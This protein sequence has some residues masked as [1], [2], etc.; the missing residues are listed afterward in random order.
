MSA[1]TDLTDEE[2]LELEEKTGEA[3]RRQAKAFWPSAWRMLKLMGPLKL[4]FGAGVVLNVVSVLLMVAGPAV[5]GMAIDVIARGDMER[6]SDVVMWLLV[7]YTG[8]SFADWA[9]G[10]VINRAVMRA[11][12]DL[13]ASIEAKVHDLPLSYFDT[14]QRGDL[15]SRTT[16]DVD[17]VQ[18]A[19]QQAMGHLIHSAIMLTGIVVMMFSISWELALVALIAVP[20]SGLVIAVLGTRSQKQFSQQW[21]STGA[22]NGHVEEAF[23]GHEVAL[24]FGRTDEMENEFDR[25]NAELFGSAFK[26]QFLSGTI[27]PTMQFITYLSYVVIA[28]V[29]ALRVA[30]G[31]ITL[32]SAVAFIQYSRQL[33]Q[34][35]G[36]LGGMLQMLQSGVASAERI[37][38]FLDAPAQSTDANGILATPARGL[39]EFDDVSFSYSPDT[40]LIE[41]LTLRVE[42]GQTAAIVGPTGAGKTTLVN[43]LMRFYDIDRGEIRLDGVDTRSVPRA[44]LRGEIGMVLQ[45]AVLFKGT[46]MENTRYGHLDATDEEVIAAAR[47]TYVDRFVRTLADGYD[48]VVDLDSGAISA[49]ERQLITIARAFLAQPSVLILDEATSSVDTRTEVLVQEAMGSLRSGR[50]AFVIAH[51]LSTIRDA[52]TILVMEA[53]R[54]VEQGP[55]DELMARRGVYWRMQQP[56]GAAGDF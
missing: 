17:N 43:L 2:F 18:Q 25:R 55:H 56:D 29:G 9:S 15:L 24:I 40:P 13:R 44:A 6:L 30:G 21:R 38:E 52:D 48:T 33:N 42:P 54:I 39:V 23:T 26:A 49:G 28:V 37:F 50:T 8:A 3:G 32:G 11:V 20:L 14:R 16:N 45:D 22:L 51:R 46:I 10:A 47:A 36:E 27:F 53:G 41:D 31:H 4:A 7:I 5:L 1:K 34:P 12:Y 19:L 35:L